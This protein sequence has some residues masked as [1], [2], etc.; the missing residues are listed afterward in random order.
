[1][2]NDA[3]GRTAP[4]CLGCLVALACAISAAGTTQDAM[5]SP[6]PRSS[7]YR[8]LDFW[9]GEWE[10]ETAQGKPAGKS[11]IEL[12]LEQCIVF[13]NWT[14]DNGYEGKSFNLYVRKTGKWVQVWVDNMGQMI[15][16]E[17]EARDGSLYYRAEVEARDGR[18]ALRRMTLSP[19]GEDR[20]RQFSERSIDGGSTWS[21]EYELFYKRKK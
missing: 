10:V 6:C 21:P 13:E 8:A 7:E 20:V 3:S 15:R 12:L 14:G 19:Q 5:T 1:M 11:R 18:R 2:W 9:L 16:F 4:Q 17:G